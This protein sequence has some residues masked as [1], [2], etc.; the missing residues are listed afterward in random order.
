[1]ANPRQVHTQLPSW[2]GNPEQ[3]EDDVQPIIMDSI[4]DLQHTPI[5]W[6]STLSV[7]QRANLIIKALPSPKPWLANDVEQFEA[8]LK[9]VFKPRFMQYHAYFP[10]MF[11]GIW[12]SHA[13]ETSS[14]VQEMHPAAGFRMCT[15]ELLIRALGAN[16]GQPAPAPAAEHRDHPLAAAHIRNTLTSLRNLWHHLASGVRRQQQQQHQTP[17]PPDHDQ[18]EDDGAPLRRVWARGQ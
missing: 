10:G 13:R 9:I 14:R 4:T 16:R 2:V 15:S 6:N 18:Q 7:E 11:Q 5:W 1:M 3:L 8:Q 17:P 12:E